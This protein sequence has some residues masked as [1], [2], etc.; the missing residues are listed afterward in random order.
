MQPLRYA[1]D[2]ALAF[3]QLQ[4]ETGSDAILLTIPDSDTRLRYPVTAEAAR[5]PTIGELVQAIDTLNT[6]MDAAAR[7]GDTPTLTVFYSG[8]GARTQP[9][10]G[11]EAAL[12]LHDGL[13]SQTALHDMLGKLRAGIVHLVIDAC[14]AEALLRSRDVDAQTVELAPADMAML[15]SQSTSARYPHIGVVIASR[16]APAHEWDTYQSGVFRTR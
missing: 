3:Y 16:N 7:A 2:D 8:H 14:Y 11:G 4:K 12:T 6:R 10:G 9:D 13:L 15:L 1:D 5:A